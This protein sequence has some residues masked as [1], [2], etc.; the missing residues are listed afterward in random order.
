MLFAIS[1]VASR[2]LRRRVYVLTSV[3][4]FPNFAGIYNVVS[5]SQLIFPR[6]E[7]TH[8]AFAAAVRYSVNETSYEISISLEVI[9]E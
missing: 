7:S 6:D 1:T 5:G 4:D 3:L 9:E 2:Y 8:R